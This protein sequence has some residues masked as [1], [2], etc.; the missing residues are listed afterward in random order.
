MDKTGKTSLTIEI[1]SDTGLNLFYVKL[2]IVE[3]NITVGVL[4]NLSTVLATTQHLLF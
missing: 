1:K 2:E 3:G 4:L